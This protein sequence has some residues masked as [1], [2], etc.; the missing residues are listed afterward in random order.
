MITL[1]TAYLLLI[2]FTDKGWLTSSEELEFVETRLKWNLNNFRRDIVLGK[3][4]KSQ[5]R[6]VTIY[7]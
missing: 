6:F 4:S 7:L 1:I 3:E 5:F 2:V